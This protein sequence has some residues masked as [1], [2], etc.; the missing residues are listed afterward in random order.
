MRSCSLAWFSVNLLLLTA[1]YA[2]FDEPELE[3][4]NSLDVLREH[5]E[6]GEFQLAV[7]EVSIQINEIR[8]ESGNFSARLAEPYIVLGDAQLGL[9]EVEDAVDSFTTALK[10]TRMNKG[11]NSTDQ[12]SSLYRIAAAQAELGEYQNANEAHERAY[13]IML[14]QLGSKNPQ[15]LPSMLNLIDWYESNRRFSAAKILYI[16]AIQIAN[17]AIP[18]DD[19]RQVELARAF[20]AGMRNTVF[21]PMDGDS[22][23]RGFDVEVPGYEPPPPGKSPPSSY[24]LGQRALI[25]V[26]NF[27]ETHAPSDRETIA[28]AKLNLADWHQLFGR[29]SKATRMY[30]DIW[31]ELDSLPELRKSFFSEPKILYIRLPEFSASSDT[32]QFGVVELLLTVSYRGAVTGRISQVVEP[33]NTDI[34]FRTRVAAR[35]ARFRPAIKDGR[36]LTTRDF[37]LTHYYPLPKRTP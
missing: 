30:R 11:L 8:K 1:N 22:R 24:S 3:E 7:D 26:V 13:A 10:V 37:L 18:K 32:T 23:Y 27:V 6:L 2:A 20:A 14:N 21:P 19:V 31:V 4:T 33:P 29:E 34:E 12:M 36:P 15:L 5:V 35:E 9:G 17:R 28:L 25:D 16:E